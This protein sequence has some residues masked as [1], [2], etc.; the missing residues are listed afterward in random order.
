M[1]ITP[2]TITTDVERH[3]WDLV[4]KGR[5]RHYGDHDV[6]AIFDEIEKLR[7]AAPLAACRMEGYMHNMCGRIDESFE[8]LGLQRGREANEAGVAFDACAMLSNLG[9]ISEAQHYFEKAAH[10]MTGN[11]S[12]SVELG[13]ASGSI[14][15]LS[16][17]IPVARKMNLTNL[18]RVPVDTIDH[19]SNL[20]REMNVSDD[21]LGSVMDVMGKVLRDHG[22]MFYGQV[23][24][25]VFDV[26]D[27]LRAVRLCYQVDATPSQALG[28]EMLFVEALAEADIFVPPALLLSIEGV[29]A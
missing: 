19:A 10:P 14:Q 22:L 12:R 23:G 24:L 18:D 4:E 11:F 21:R 1:S 29:R 26:P 27:E 20:L 17:F 8:S 6:I 15:A 25:E 2:E 7:A 5:L 16:S 13:I 28:L 9:Y 3:V